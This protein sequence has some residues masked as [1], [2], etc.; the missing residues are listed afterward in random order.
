MHRRLLCAAWAVL[1]L[2]AGTSFG[3]VNRVVLQVNDHIA[4]LH[5][6]RTRYGERLRALQAAP[7]PEEERAT[8]LAELG[9]SVFREMFDEL[10]L[11]S[12]AS[13]EGTE[14]T[15]EMVT[16]AVDSMREANGLA[17]EEAFEAALASSGMTR[18]MLRDQA[19]RSLLLQQVTAREIQ[20]RIDLE[21]EDLRR[22]YQSHLEQFAVPARRQLRSVVVLESSALDEGARAALAGEIADLL[23]S[24]S[25]ALAE[26]LARRS[27]VGETTEL[28][29]LG[30]VEQGDLA[31]AIEAAVWS[32][33]PGSVSEPVA[34]RGGLHV[35]EVVAAEAA[36]V[37]PFV[38]VRDEV[39]Q[40]ELLRLQQEAV[41]AMLTDLE[42]ASFIRIDPPPEAAGFRTTRTLLEEPVGEVAPPGDAAAEGEADGR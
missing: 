19:R 16:S 20:S 37:R 25:D 29:D 15:D 1:A 32:L 14:V 17:D 38:E 6:Y 42:S 26:E 9:E 3:D 39:E 30:W 13:H 34:A 10:L 11:L 23:R 2:A 8:R 28:V 12:K 22:Y 41:T 33:E 40:L 31:P 5:D 36:D 35:V 18:A 27:A 24:G 7:I 4:T 21:E